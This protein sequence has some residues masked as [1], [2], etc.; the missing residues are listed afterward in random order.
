MAHVKHTVSVTAI[1]EFG[2]K[3]LFVR[4]NPEEGNFGGKWVF[5]GGKV[6]MGED[7]IQALFRELD[8]EV[9]VEHTDEV[10]LL[11]AYQF[12]R[13]ED[14]SSSQG[15]VF[16]VRAKN[17]A[18]KLDAESFDDSRW[19]APEEIV[20]FGDKTI[21]GMEVHV[22]NAVIAL[23]KNLFLDRNWLSVTTYQGKHSSMDE[24]YIRNFSEDVDATL[25]R[26]EFF[27]HR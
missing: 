12:S 3:F 18:V 27:P 11:T 14:Q 2:G 4:R 16:L 13:A 17:D 15:L 25:E 8:E 7:V 6:E 21:Y 19:I 26:K 1:I 5:P 9:A 20:D 23:K 22:R 24:E 10:A